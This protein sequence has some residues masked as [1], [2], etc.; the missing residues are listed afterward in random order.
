MASVNGEGFDRPGGLM[1]SMVKRT[2]AL[3]TNLRGVAVTLGAPA[4]DEDAA[5]DGDAAAA[6]GER[7]DDGGGRRDTDADAAGPTMPKHV[8]ETTLTS[9]PSFLTLP[10][11]TFTYT[12]EPND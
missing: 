8:P 5:A 10:I 2:S 4:G 7:V 11:R 3:G 6:A 1:A 12:E 9:D